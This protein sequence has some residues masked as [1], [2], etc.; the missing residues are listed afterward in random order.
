M[1]LRFL[2]K[3]VKNLKIDHK[4]LFTGPLYE[5]D[6]MKAYV[7]ADIYV[8]PSI[9]E[10]FGV[11]VLEA[12]A[13]NTPVICSRRCGI[14]DVIDGRAGF[15]VS[16]DK[17]QLRDAMIKVL[18]DERLRRKFGEESRKLVREEFGWDKVVLDIENT[19]L[20]LVK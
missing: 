3:Q 14:A 8:L 9:Y 5:K 1:D 15:A 19:Y 11:A 4:V 12:C 20:N 17:D 13:C 10:I 18:G 16:Y 2:K 7:D 6:K